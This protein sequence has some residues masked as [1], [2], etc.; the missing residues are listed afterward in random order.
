MK[1]FQQLTQ[2]LFAILLFMLVLPASAQYFNE[3]IDLLKEDIARN[4]EM[5]PS[6]GGHVTTGYSRAVASGA[7]PPVF[8]NLVKY[9]VVGT[10]MWSRLYDFGTGLAR[11]NDVEKTADG[12]F[13]IAGHAISPVSGVPSAVLIKTDALGTALWSQ[14]YDFS[15]PYS[16]AFSVEE[17]IIPGLGSTYAVTGSY[18]NPFNG[19]L[20]V[21]VLHADAAG[22]IL[23]MSQFDTGLDE[24]GQ[25]IK[26]G[27]GLFGGFGPAY[28]VSGYST[29]GAAAGKNVFVTGL[30]PAMTMIWGEVYG[31]P[32]DEEGRA[33]EVLPSGEVLVSG[34]STSFSNGRSD[35]FV[36]LLDPFG[37]P[38]W[39]NI[40][41][42][43]KDEE[44]FSIELFS[45][46]TFVTAGWTNQTSTGSRDMAVL[47]ADLTGAPI[48]S[49]VFGGV[50]DDIGY[51]VKESLSAAGA[52]SQILL[53]GT[54]GIA[55]TAV[56]D[57]RDIYTVKTNP[58]GDSSCPRNPNF[59]R[60]LVMANFD[61]C[62]LPAMSLAYSTPAPVL[63]PHVPP[64]VTDRC[65]SCADMTVSYTSAP[66]VF[67]AGTPVTFTNTS[68]C[69][70]EYRWYVNGTLVSSSLDL[71]YTFA[72]PGVY[73]ITLYGRNAG[74]PVKSYTTSILVSCSPAPKIIEE[75]IPGSL[76]LAPNPAQSD[77]LLKAQLGEGSGNL[78]YVTVT[79]MTGRK[80][81]ELQAPVQDG[82]VQ[83]QLQ[84]NSWTEGM[85]LLTLWSDNATL[86]QR[87]QVAR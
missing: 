15:G 54:Y 19:T 83:I 68:A 34:Y 81:A 85:Y 9:D 17:V 80:V 73:T 16:E 1:T 71:I 30:S 35:F 38:I 4:V 6:D 7:V 36:S 84:T 49:R 51:S 20:D 26:P 82:L 8:A 10:V 70:D 27:P 29:F 86:T 74:C 64:V 11:G 69:V 45:D 79:D 46:G 41:G 63:D 60:L 55:P 72:A 31:G 28:Y 67:C 59:L 37:T 42:R 76:T 32:K 24:E 43:K 65:C 57:D 58:S 48:F 33:L 3:T 18:R 52:S 5:D 78:A 40:Y 23:T 22:F 77:V 21:F 14:F 75:V 53:A 13:I 50:R 44:A 61:N 47:R 66:L 25:S 56:T 87:L 12:G 62:M 2:S 39:Q